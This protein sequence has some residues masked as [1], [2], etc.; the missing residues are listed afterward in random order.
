MKPSRVPFFRAAIA[1][2]VL[3]WALPASAI[4][5]TGSNGR[6]V[7]F[8]LIKSATP[9]GITAQMVADGPVL[10]MFRDG[11]D[12]RR[13]ARPRREEKMTNAVTNQFVDEEGSPELVNI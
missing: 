11:D 9:K 5:L 4:T 6:A 8:F 1:A 10:G 3:V 13:R 2:V 12:Q 7:E